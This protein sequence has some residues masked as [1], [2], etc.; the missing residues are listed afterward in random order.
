MTRDTHDTHDTFCVKNARLKNKKN[1]YIIH[2]K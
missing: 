2:E 1:N